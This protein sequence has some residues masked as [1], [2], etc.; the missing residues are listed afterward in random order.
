MTPSEQRILLFLIT[1]LL[2]GN[3]LSLLGW[4]PKAD[5]SVAADSLNKAVQTDARLRLDIRIATAEEL[6]TLS[7][8]GEKRATEII[9]FRQK[10]PFT[11]VNQLLQIKGIGA[12]TY[13]KLLPDLLV[14]GDSTNLELAAEKSPKTIK[15]KAD[16][17]DK[18]SP[19]PVNLNTASLEELCTLS[20]IGEVKARAILEWRKANG[21][22]VS[23]EDI[24]KVKGIGA[25]TLE[26]NRDRLRVN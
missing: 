24:T 19:N 1:V 14:F 10:S 20:G 9:A 15:E 21:A 12:K 25:K 11:S 18:S 8:I 23:I 26:K 13:A 22:F 2:L 4:T 16:K 3:T 6:G 17:Q 5:A 7:G